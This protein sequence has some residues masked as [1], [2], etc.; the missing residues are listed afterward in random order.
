MGEDRLEGHLC[1]LYLY[2]EV[3]GIGGLNMDR[4]FWITEELQK[5]PDEH[6]KVGPIV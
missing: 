4:Q 2:E 5:N 3:K 1:P 6:V